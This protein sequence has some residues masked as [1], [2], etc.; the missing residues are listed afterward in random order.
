MPRTG[1]AKELRCE[2]R[3]VRWVFKGTRDAVHRE[4]RC[5]RLEVWVV[6]APA[7]G[8]GEERPHAEDLCSSQ[9]CSE[10]HTLD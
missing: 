8:A 10:A 5:R 4:V 6:L 1:L 2:R 7:S 9:D 3:L